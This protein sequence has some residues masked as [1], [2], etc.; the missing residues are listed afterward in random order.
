[1]RFPRLLSLLSLSLC[2]ATLLGLA[3]PGS[4]EALAAAKPIA[5]VSAKSISTFLTLFRKARALPDDEIRRLAHIAADHPGGTKE[6]GEIL[7]KLKLPNDALED[8]FLR[9]A[10]QQDRLDRREAEAFFRHLQGKE[11]FRTTLRKAIGNSNVGTVG[12]LN[13]LRI[14]NEAA[15]HGFEVRAIGLKFDDPSKPGGLTDID[16]LLKRKGKLVAI[17]AK[18]YAEDTPILPDKFRGD[19]ETLVNFKTSRLPEEVIPIFSMTN[20]PADDRVW[21]LLEEAAVSRRVELITGPPE[22]QIHLIKQLLDN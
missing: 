4:A 1:M 3:Y 11:G 9:I 2:S 6:V 19:M 5:A 17:E 22:Q 15:T 13:E 10:V 7:G 20:R 16:V 12:H 14:A 21:R 18:A 8:T